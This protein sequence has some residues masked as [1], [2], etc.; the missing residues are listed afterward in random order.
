M[1]PDT[2][3]SPRSTRGAAHR[4]CIQCGRIFPSREPS[5][6]VCPVCQPGLAV[7]RPLT[8]FDPWLA[9]PDR[10]RRVESC[11]AGG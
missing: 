9:Y 2:L 10:G 11:S 3:P 5:H 4:P 7:L 8:R 1:H 6:R